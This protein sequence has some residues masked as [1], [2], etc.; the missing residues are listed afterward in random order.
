MHDS[1]SIND[2]RTT[3]SERSALEPRNPLDSDFTIHTMT[4]TLFACSAPNYFELRAAASG[5]RK[6]RKTD[7]YEILFVII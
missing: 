6:I 7:V 2:F 1:I 5:K 4:A 3:D